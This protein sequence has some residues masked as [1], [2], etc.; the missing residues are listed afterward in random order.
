VFLYVD[1][2]EDQ[3]YLRQL[4]QVVVGLEIVGHCLHTEYNLK[5]SFKPIKKSL[6]NSNKAKIN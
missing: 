1:D 2:Y 5:K 4:L 3:T 6:K